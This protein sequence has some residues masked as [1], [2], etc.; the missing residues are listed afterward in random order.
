MVVKHL[1]RRL[2]SL[3]LFR[4]SRACWPVILSFLLVISTPV[5]CVVALSLSLPPSPLRLMLASRS[6]CRANPYNRGKKASQVHSVLVEE[7]YRV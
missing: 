4:L 2:F 1:Y 5:Q 6:H 7:A 3:V